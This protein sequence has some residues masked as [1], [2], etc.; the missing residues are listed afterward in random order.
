MSSNETALYKIVFPYITYAS[1]V[2]HIKSIQN[3]HSFAFGASKVGNNRSRISFAASLS[4]KLILSLPRPLLTM[5]NWILQVKLL[6]PKFK[7]SKNAKTG[8]FHSRVEKNFNIPILI[9]HIRNSPPL[10]HHLTPAIS[11]E[12][13]TA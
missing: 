5:L 2:W 3:A 7:E 8:S 13:F 12:I 6:A 9:D 10:I 4:Q 1:A 11:I